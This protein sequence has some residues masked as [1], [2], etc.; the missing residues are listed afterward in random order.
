MSMHS[1]IGDTPQYG[2]LTLNTYNSVSICEAVSEK[3][4]R[5]HYSQI[6]ENR[7]KK[8]RIQFVNL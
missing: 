3:I 6:M 8:K 4:I 7:P 5:N 2:A 1:T